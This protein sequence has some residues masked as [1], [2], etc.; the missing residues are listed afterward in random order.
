MECLTAG[1]LPHTCAFRIRVRLG[2]GIHSSCGQQ[3]WR[4]KAKDG[5]RDQR[6]NG[7]PQIQHTSVCCVSFL[8]LSPG[9]LPKPRPYRRSRFV[10]SYS[11][12]PSKA[13]SQ[14]EVVVHC[15]LNLLLRSQITFGGL[16]RGLAEQEFD[17]LQISAVLSAEFAQVRRRSWAP[18]CSIPICFDDCST[19]DQIAQSPSSSATSLPD[20]ES[21]RSSLPFSSLTAAIQASI[22]CFAQIGTATVRI[23]PPLP[24][25][26]MITQPSYPELNVFDLQRG[27]FLPAQSATDEKS[28]DHIIALAL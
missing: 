24:R 7:E 6:T 3:V 4:T 22:P 27:E 23:R 16:D 26:S 10:C 5:L 21:S 25:R 15:N 28:D 2:P 8:E 18:K 17:L 9:S 13:P 11:Y 19:T 14:S 20:F 1:C 12:C